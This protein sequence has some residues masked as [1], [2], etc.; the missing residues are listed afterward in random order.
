MGVF[1]RNKIYAAFHEAPGHLEKLEKSSHK[2]VPWVDDP[3]KGARKGDTFVFAQR[4]EADTIELFFDLFFV[5]N[6]ATFTA[7]HAVLDLESFGA[8]VGFFAIIWSTWFQVTLHDVRF[9]RDSVYERICKVIQMIVF[10]GFALVGSKFQPT[11][12][13]AIDT[14]VSPSTRSGFIN[15]A[16]HLNSTNSRLILIVFWPNHFLRSPQI[17]RCRT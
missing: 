11:S 3:F 14:A 13:K 16:M 2:E 4:H 10:V 6:L 5:A 1:H 9:S 8:Y 7:Y 15:L 12:K 17:Y